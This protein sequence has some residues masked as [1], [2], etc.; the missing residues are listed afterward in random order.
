MTKFLPSYISNMARSKFDRIL[1]F[2]I[3]VDDGR[4]G[5]PRSQVLFWP[6]GETPGN[7]FELLNLPEVLS[8]A[9]FAT[10]LDDPRRP[11][12]GGLIGMGSKVWVGVTR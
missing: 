9:S 3:I 4:L 1:E 5:Q 8:F 12:G 2:C 10:F 11:G 7:E 6:V